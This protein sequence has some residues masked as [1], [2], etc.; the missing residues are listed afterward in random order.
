M[1]SFYPHPVQL[2]SKDKQ[3]LTMLSCEEKKYV[4]DK[5]GLDV[6]VQYPFTEEFAN[7]NPEE[8]MTLL[9]RLTS[10]KVLVVGENYCFGKGRAGNIDTLRTLG[11]AMG[12]KVIGIPSV[13]VMES[14]VSSTRIRGLIAQGEMEQ[15]SIM[16]DKPYFIIGEVV[17]G[18][19]RGRTFNFPTLNMLPQRGK[20]LP[21]D[22]VYLSSVIDGDKEYFSMSNIG[23][24]PTFEG[25]LRCVET[26]VP[27]ID[28][29]DM[30]GKKVIVCIYKR[31]RGE[32]RF[33]DAT[34]L[35]AQLKADKATC[36]KW[37]EE[38]TALIKPL[39]R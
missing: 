9:I 38:K 13:K 15:V 27:D 21:P 11:E 24:N 37:V 14:R 33:K 25:K 19:E 28:L 3:F 36:A 32:H 35:V 8:F 30:Y 34:E 26:N 1:F 2:F 5:M 16:L 39:L 10:C 20:L 4:A 22:G 31:V 23:T 6:L 17:H 18:N 7:L 12:V 29:G